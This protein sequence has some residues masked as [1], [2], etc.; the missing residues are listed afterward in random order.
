MPQ[1]EEYSGMPMYYPP[2]EEYY[3]QAPFSPQQAYYPFPPPF[4]HYPQHYQQV[5]PPQAYYPAPPQPQLIPNGAAAPESTSSP[6]DAPSSSSANGAPTSPEVQRA[7]SPS[8]QAF[9][10]PSAPQ[11]VPLGAAQPFVPYPQ[12]QF[13]PGQGPEQYGYQQVPT[14]P[15]TVFG[16]DGLPLPVVGRQERTPS[17]HTFFQTGAAPTPSSQ[18]PVATS[19]APNG[20]PKGA[21]RGPAAAS[22]SPSALNARRSLPPMNGGGPNGFNN[23]NKPRPRFPPGTPRPPCSFFEANRCKNRDTCPFAHP[24]PDGTDARTLGQGWMGADGRTENPEMSGGLP[25]VWLANPRFGNGHGHHRGAN[26]AGQGGQGGAF[27]KGPNNFNGGYSVREP[28]P[29]NR[30]EEE[31]DRAVRVEQQQNAAQAAA[32]ATTTPA[33][34]GD[35]ETTTEATSSTTTPASTESKPVTPQQPLTHP[36]PPAPHHHHQHHQHHNGPRVHHN[37]PFV[38]GAAAGGRVPGA[39]APQ[40]VAAINGITRGTRSSAPSS[41]HHQSNSHAN[42]NN[43]NNA[44]T[45]STSTAAATP[46]VIAQPQ[47]VP[48]GADFPALSPALEG[49]TSAPLANVEVNPA[50]PSLASVVEAS[51]PAAAPAPVKKEVPVVEQQQQEPEHD[52]VMVSHADA[53]PPTPAAADAAPAP[54]AVVDETPAPAPAPV[55]AAPKPILSF[56]SAA[57][58]GAAVVL[59]E[60]PKRVSV[61][62]TPAAAKAEKVE[63]KKVAGD[64]KKEGQGQKKGGKGKG[65]KKVGGQGQGAQGGVKA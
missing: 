15:P 30:F 55:A 52:F 58:R 9:P 13:V 4:Q 33:T 62:P 44:S 1:P 46:A 45:P 20:F 5:P 2:M 11:Q 54:T 29:R 61:M 56:A 47:R 64:E 59:P 8:T 51:T 22:S 50:A 57:A 32:Q 23:N 43:N 36:L 7:L 28:R 31:R 10:S 21:P 34:N 27:V 53:T 63:E 42:N 12:Q 37:G 49:P 26:G 35:A 3:G 41:Q 39:S 6:V 24:L 60:K 18:Q 14:S 16:P 17:L 19:S 25:A 40:L 65:G 48:S 38:N